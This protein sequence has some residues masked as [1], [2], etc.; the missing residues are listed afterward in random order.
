MAVTLTANLS[1]W[2][3]VP[4]SQQADSVASQPL[5]NTK[6]PNS[7]QDIMISVSIVI[8]LSQL[9]AYY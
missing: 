4:I 5:T 2:K 8:L 6:Y 1:K 7:G 9:Q 3:T